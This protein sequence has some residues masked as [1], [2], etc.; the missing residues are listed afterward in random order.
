M[1]DNNVDSLKVKEFVE[2]AT[3]RIETIHGVQNFRLKHCTVKNDLSDLLKEIEKD[4]LSG[5]NCS[6]LFDEKGDTKS[7]YL[8]TKEMAQHFFNFPE[9]IIVDGTYCTNSSKFPLYF[10]QVCF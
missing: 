5:G 3:G 4:N 8:Q 9:Y 2:K 6:I 1:L 7:L 10:I